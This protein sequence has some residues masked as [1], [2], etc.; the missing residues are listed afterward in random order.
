MGLFISIIGTVIFVIFFIAVMNIS[1]NK[2]E[3][4]LW[5]G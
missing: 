2:Q 4:Y 5:V 3:V 1:V